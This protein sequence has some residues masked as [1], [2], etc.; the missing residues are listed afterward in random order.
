LALARVDVLP[1]PGSEA[2]LIELPSRQGKDGRYDVFFGGIERKAVQAEEQVH[3]LEGHPLVAV[4]EG[5]VLR[6]AES[7][8]CSEGGE[9]GVVLVAESISR[10]FEG[11]VQESPIAEAEGPAVSL[12]LIGV[13]RENVDRSEPAGFGHFA[14][15]RMALR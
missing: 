9:V 2:G 11:G 6:D 1:K 12:D 7:V 15:S 10:T 4:D 14:S 8:C 5:V 13:D 3:G